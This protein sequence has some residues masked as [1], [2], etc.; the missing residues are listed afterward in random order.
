VKKKKKKKKKPIIGVFHLTSV[1]E[2]RPVFDI[3]FEF[4][5]DSH[6]EDVHV[7]MWRHSRLHSSTPRKHIP[8]KRARTADLQVVAH[9]QQTS[10]PD[11]RNREGEN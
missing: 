10:H 4:K 6:H 1:P 11:I 2:K 5:E 9:T 7:E 8:R 3:I